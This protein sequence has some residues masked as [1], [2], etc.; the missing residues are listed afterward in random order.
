MSRDAI[1]STEMLQTAN[2]R[3]GQAEKSHTV[4]PGK[5]QLLKIHSQRLEQE[6]T[7]TE[8]EGPAADP[9]RAAGLA[10]RR[11]AFRQRLEDFIQPDD[12]FGDK[13]P[14]DEQ[15]FEIDGRIQEGI[16]SGKL[17]SDEKLYVQGEANKS[18]HLRRDFESGGWTSWK[19]QLYL[20]RHDALNRVMQDYMKGDYHPQGS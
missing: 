6:E 10:D 12:T 17:N 15:F 13:M 3:I 20:E 19:K 5:L 2:Q 8:R 9:G 14:D 11:E 4:S 7:A 1:R 16:Q 18:K